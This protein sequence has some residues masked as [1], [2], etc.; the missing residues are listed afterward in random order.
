MLRTTSALSLICIMWANFTVADTEKKEPS[1]CERIDAIAESVMK[2]R[3]RGVPMAKMYKTVE[4]DDYTNKLF[5]LL[6]DEAYKVNRYGTE[7]YQEKAVTDF[8]DI[9]F[10]ACLSNQ[11]DRKA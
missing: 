2:A 7:E 3:Q 10:R 6:I 11:N 1:E 5:K 9:Y 8:R 4:G